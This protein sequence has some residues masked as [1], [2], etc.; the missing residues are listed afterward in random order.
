M[1][2]NQLKKMNIAYE[3]INIEHDPAARDFLIAAGHKTMPQI[4][5]KGKLFVE[6]GAQG[7]QKLSEDTIRVRIAGVDLDDFQL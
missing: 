1:A 5:H 7:L 4:Y 3:E 2:K 6:G